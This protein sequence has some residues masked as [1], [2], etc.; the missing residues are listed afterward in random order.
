MSPA[1]DYDTPWKDAVTRYF[2][3]FMAFYFHEAYTEIDWQRPH[4]FLEQELAQVVRDAELGN[5]RVDKLVR[6]SKCGGGEEWVFVHIDVQS[7]FDRHFAERVFTYNYRI[8]D[9]YRRP[10]ASL[11]LLA[12]GRSNWRP[13]HFGYAAFGCET[14]I[15]F[16]S[17]K[18]NDFAPELDRLLL[19]PNVFAL[20][21]AA[22]L[23][24]QQTK[25]RDVQRHEAKWRLS[26]MLYERDWDRQRVVDLFNIIDWMMRIPD[27]LQRKLMRDISELER[28]RDMP[29]IN[30]FER[31]GLEQG[32]KEGRQQGQQEMLSNQLEKRFGTLPQSVKDRLSKATASQLRAWSEAVLVAPSLDSIF[33]DR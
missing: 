29:Y 17:V 10:V 27:S 2:P 3:E 25:G 13:S 7:A 11:A 30:S 24:T 6:V 1:D 20:V 18:L 9:R 8:D 5:R 32:R 31:A 12:D 15:R 4:V 23:L 28:T 26:R 21:T 19:H 33:H 22:H 14:G 16:P